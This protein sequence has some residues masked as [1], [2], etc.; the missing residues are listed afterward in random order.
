ME[1]EGFV[2]RMGMIEPNAML[3]DKLKRYQPLFPR[4]NRLPVF[5]EIKSL[6]L[7]KVFVR[8]HPKAP[9]LNAFGW[10]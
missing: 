5:T 2:N 4:V 8:R 6:L 1:I 3:L 10:V 9:P 7:T